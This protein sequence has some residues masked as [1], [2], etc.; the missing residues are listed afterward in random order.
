M[1]EKSPVT[2]KVSAFLNSE[3][4][5][6]PVTSSPWIKEKTLLRW[7]K[8]S[9]LSALENDSCMIQISLFL[10]WMKNFIEDSFKVLPESRPSCHFQGNCI[11]ALY[12]IVRGFRISEMTV[13]SAIGG[14]I[15]I[16]LN[17][18]LR[19]WIVTFL[20]LKDY[21]CRM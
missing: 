19:Y 4:S 6:T 5:T 16:N 12:W 21:G 11:D 8:V 15:C 9:S 18:C 2:T 1:E 13:S 10:F 3:L 7:L 14:R 17:H 20:T